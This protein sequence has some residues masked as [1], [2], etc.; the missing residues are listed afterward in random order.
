MQ[1]AFDVQ[2]LIERLKKMALPEA[3]KL[4]KDIID[5]VLFGWVSDS[6]AMEAAANPLYAI[7]VPLIGALKQPIDAELAV[8][9]PDLPKA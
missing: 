2:D 9:M 1:K 5:N 4:A 8:L 6:L 3:E 7:G